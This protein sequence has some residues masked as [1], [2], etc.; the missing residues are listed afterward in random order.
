[1]GF[2]AQVGGDVVDGFLAGRVCD[3]FDRLGFAVVKEGL[4]GGGDFD[5]GGVV[6][7]RG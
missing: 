6:G 2:D 5:V 7:R 3:F 1:M 4:L